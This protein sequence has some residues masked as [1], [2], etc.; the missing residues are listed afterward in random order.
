MNGFI[1]ILPG[2]FYEEATGLPWSTKRSLGRGKG[3]STDG[4]LKR[5]NCK[6]SHG[7]YYVKVEGRMKSWH[8][9]IFEHFNGII[10]SGFQV[11]HINNIRTDNRITNLQLLSA[12][13]NTRSCLK[14]KRNTSG[15]PGV[16]WHKGKQ[17]WLAGIRINGKHKHLGYFN[18]K[19]EASEA[20]KKAKIKYHGSDSIRF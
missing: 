17:K 7:Y 8:R 13:D 14:Y 3:F 15:Y 9:L 12:A 1:E 6:N 11:D 10:P 4:D 5:L 19:L 20:F 2:I 18:D 16:C